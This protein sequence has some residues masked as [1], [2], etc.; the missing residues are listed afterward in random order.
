MYSGSMTLSF[1]SPQPQD[2]PPCSCPQVPPQV[3]GQHQPPG[4]LHGCQA[5]SDDWFVCCSL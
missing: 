3:A 5:P 4:C 1:I 2:L